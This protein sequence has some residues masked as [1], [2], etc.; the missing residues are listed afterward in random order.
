MR[1]FADKQKATQQATVAKSTMSRRAPFGQSCDVNSIPRSQ[2]T[3]G[4]QAVQRSRH[5]SA[6]NVELRSGTDATTSVAHDFS[7]IPVYHQA[8]AALERVHRNG[9]PPID[10]LSKDGEVPDGPYVDQAAPATPA[11]APAPAPAAPAAPATPTNFLQLLTGWAPGANRYGFQLS[12][13]CRSTSGDVGDLQN[14]APNLIWRERVT[15]PRNDFAGRINPPDPTIL[16]AG[17]VSFAPASTRRVGPNLLEF[18]NVTDTHWMPTAAVRANDF[19]PAGPPPP[20]GFIGPLRPPLPAVMESR[21]LYQ[22]SPDGGGTWRYF[23]GAFIIRRTLSRDSG[24]LRFRTQKTGVHTV[25]EP[26]KP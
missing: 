17:G 4:N 10:V 24:G 3:I 7:R 9:A 22:Y 1:T 19:Q 6:E 12:F 25:A 16:P 26:Y 23:A 18:N 15:Y 11:P 13:R 21:Q 14:Q 8:P 5:V 20:P 2:R